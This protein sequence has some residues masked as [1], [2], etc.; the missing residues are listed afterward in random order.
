[1]NENARAL[2][3]DLAAERLQKFYMRDVEDCGT[4][5][6]ILGHAL[7]RMGRLNDFIIEENSEIKKRGLQASRT[8]YKSTHDAYEWLG[9]TVEAGDSLC[10]FAPWFDEVWPEIKGSRFHATQPEA[11]EAL[12]RACELS[13]AANG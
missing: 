13:E 3:E 1:M 6:C 7:H 11:A 10:F 8:D 2:Y 9:L 12:K 5:Q 4:P